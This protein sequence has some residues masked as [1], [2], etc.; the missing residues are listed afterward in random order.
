MTRR[1]DPRFSKRQLGRLLRTFREQAGMTQPEVA[2]TMDWS[3][4]KLIRIEKAAVGIST[5]DLK[6]LLAEYG[7]TDP[8]VVADLVDVARES[9][10]QPWYARYDAVTTEPFRRLLAYEGSAAAIH[11][12]HPLLVPGHLQT[13]DYARAVLATVYSGDELDLALEARISRQAQLEGPD[14]PRLVALVDESAV[15]RAVGGPDVLRE[16]LRY[17]LDRTLDDLVTLRVVPLAKG[18]H[19]GLAGAF[20]LI[21]LDEEIAD[22][23]LF[24]ENVGQD[25]LANG[26]SDKVTA[27][28]ERF[29]AI[30]QVAL[31]EQQT[32][33]LLESLVA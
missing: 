4:S 25:Y 18:A 15:R 27:A 21:E 1:R 8:E 16:Q 14:R 29:L 12:F 11:Q 20:L 26:D 2:A 22:T 6:A 3:V 33:T 23:V 32:R 28:W 19:P 10:E 24:E 17:L 31:T 9:R 13:P 5:N 30:E 7:T